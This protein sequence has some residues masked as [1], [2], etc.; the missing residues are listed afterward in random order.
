M[1]A[2]TLIENAIS[3]LQDKEGSLALSSGTLDEGQYKGRM[4]FAL[5]A[6]DS[7]GISA[8]QTWIAMS[9]AL[10]EQRFPKVVETEFVPSPIRASRKTSMYE[11]ECVCG[12]IVHTNSRA[13]DC[14]ACGAKGEYMP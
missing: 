12:H 6:A 8:M 9:E 2:L 10:R 13:F 7:E 11:F 3:K 14:P 5:V 4:V 1:K